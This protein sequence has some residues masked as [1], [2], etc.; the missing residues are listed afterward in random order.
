MK[1]VNCI[2]SCLVDILLSPVASYPEPKICTNI[3][4]DKL[5][6]SPGGGATNCSLSLAKMGVNVHLFSKIGNDLQGDYLQEELKVAGVKTKKS[7][8]KTDKKSTST[9]IVGVNLD[10]ERS[11]MSYHGALA[12]FGLNDLD[13]EDLYACDILVYPDLFNL[14]RIDGTPLL[15]L[16]E[17]A[18]QRGILTILDETW[19]VLGLQRNIFE[20]CLPFVDY[21]MPSSDDLAYLYPNEQPEDLAKFFL[22]KGVQN[23]VLK[24]GSKGVLVLNNEQ[25]FRLPAIVK[26]S[27][28][29]DTTGAGDNFSA[30]FVYGLSVEKPIDWCAEFGNKVAALSLQKLG[31]SIKKEELKSLV[32]MI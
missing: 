21:L 17:N 2:G 22:E 10:G 30:G 15:N 9:V 29:S 32:K 5:K 14:P 24:L 4:V 25:S 23:V 28:V 20:S 13:L 26:A 31:A 6:S 19:G 18:Q 27:E 12:E 1:T 16:L 11:F 7:L 3:F 8:R